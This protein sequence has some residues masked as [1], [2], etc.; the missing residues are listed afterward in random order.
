MVLYTLDIDGT[1]FTASSTNKLMSVN[2]SDNYDNIPKEFSALIEGYPTVSHPADM[3]IY[4]DGVEIFA[5]KVEKK[6]P[7]MSGDG[8]ML[9]IEGR[10]Y[11]GNL[12]RRLVERVSFEQIEPADI[13]RALLRP[14]VDDTPNP[15]SYHNVGDGIDPKGGTTSLVWS[16]S[17]DP[18]GTGLNSAVDGLD[19]SSEW[20][21]GVA[22]QSGHYYKIDL[23]SS[24]TDVCRVEF[25]SLLHD[26]E[27]AKNYRI[28]VSTDDSSYTQV[29]KKDGCT[30]RHVSHTFTKRSVR[31]IRIEITSYDAA[32]WSISFIRVYQADDDIPDIL[33]GTVDEVGTL[34]DFVSEKE[35][36]LQ[37]CY[38][39][40]EVVGWR[41][42][43]VGKYYYFQ[44]TRGS[45]I[46]G[47][48]KFEY[49]NNLIQIAPEIDIF[50]EGNHIVGWGKG[51]GVMQD[52]TR[53]TAEDATSISSYG[54]VD[55][56][57]TKGREADTTV[58]QELADNELAARK[59]PREAYEAEV[60]DSYTSG[61]WG[62]GDTVQ[63]E[64]SPLSISGGYRIMSWSRSW[65]EDVEQVTVQLSN[66]LR[67]APTVILNMI[68]SSSD[69]VGTAQGSTDFID[70]SGSANL[71]A[72][73]DVDLVVK[74]VVPGNMTD[75]LDARYYC[76]TVGTGGNVSLVITKPDG[77]TVNKGNIGSGVFMLNNQSIVD[78]IDS[79]GVYTFTL[80]ID[81]GETTC[82][83]NVWAQTYIFFPWLF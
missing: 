44:A 37:A 83:F 11:E 69:K 43:F 57:L 72:S 68:E 25:G 13:L 80:S 81:S 41:F 14:T 3:V 61:E 12:D 5:G 73:P 40:A 4:R 71:D 20:S 9:T 42:W 76:A 24:E 15:S 51:E 54:R 6:Q 60:K 2:C 74:L 66:R 48:I 52:A 78:D 28:R 39:L 31:Y 79:T 47:S 29:A 63:I 18:A 59:D 17:S 64:C 36:V 35:R 56:P 38:R 27:Y 26:S 16:V 75:I 53:V 70:G 33:E 8:R 46:S 82:Y 22:Q 7:S 49:G 45:D 21:S 1:D 65:G 77:S 32:D 34:I 55:Y 67:D 50:P 23:G 30:S 58:L 62:A 19:G 10:G